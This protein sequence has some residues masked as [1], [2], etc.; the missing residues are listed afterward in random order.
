MRVQLD[1]EEQFRRKDPKYYLKGATIE[2]TEVMVRNSD[3]PLWSSSYL[4][5]G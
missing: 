3:A 1:E 2:A 4:F 5:Q